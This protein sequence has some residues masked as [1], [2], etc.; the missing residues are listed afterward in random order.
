MPPFR[1]FL[2]HRQA[3]LALGEKLGKATLYVGYRHETKDYYLKE[4]FRK[5]VQEGVLTAIHPAFS[6][7]NLEKRG[8]KL[9]FITDL[10]EEKPNDLARAVLMEKD[11]IHCYYCGP[12]QNVPQRI[13]DAMKKAVQDENG[14]GMPESEA[15]SLMERM[16]RL[17]DRFHTECF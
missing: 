14:G 17:E 1:A 13:Q 10:I 9:Y 3:L 11:A 12:A 8:G 5:W 4:S 16:I 7:D 2:Q 15:E 6:H